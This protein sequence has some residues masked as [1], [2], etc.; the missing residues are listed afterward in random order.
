MSVSVTKDYIP[1]AAA[2]ARP[3]LSIYWG[4]LPVTVTN[5]VQSVPGRVVLSAVTPN[6][7]ILVRVF[8]AG[9]VFQP[10]ASVPNRAV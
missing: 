6:G 2:N 9:H 7:A 4:Q 1:T 5:N 10:V 8:P 3:G